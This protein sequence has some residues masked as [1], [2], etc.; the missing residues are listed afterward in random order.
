MAN[1][2]HEPKHVQAEAPLALFIAATIWCIWRKQPSNRD[3]LSMS[4]QCAFHTWLSGSNMTCKLNTFSLTN[5][6][7]RQE[8]N[9]SPSP[10]LV[11]YTPAT[12]LL[13]LRGM[14]S[15]GRG[16]GVEEEEEEGAV[17]PTTKDAV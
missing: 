8:T 15:A 5:T 12:P 16:M 14:V 6:E 2:R 1:Y 17:S 7:I 11:S 13:F 4:A 9:K 10:V 3:T